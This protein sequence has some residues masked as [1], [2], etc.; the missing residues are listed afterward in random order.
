MHSQSRG[1]TPLLLL[2][3][4]MLTNPTLVVA[5]D[6]PGRIDFN[7]DIRPILSNK[8]F[9]CHGPDAKDARRTSDSILTKESLDLPNRA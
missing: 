3:A 6:P 9:Q 8:C 5:A 1:R 4:G 2:W 7:R